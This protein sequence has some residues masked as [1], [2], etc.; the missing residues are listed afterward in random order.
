[1]GVENWTL[2][3][4]CW[5]HL[6]DDMLQV[7]A[8]SNSQLS[9]HQWVGPCALPNNPPPTRSCRH[10]YCWERQTSSTRGWMTYRLH[11]S[12]PLHIRS[13]K[14]VVQIV[15]QNFQVIQFNLSP[16]K[17]TFLLSVPPLLISSVSFTPYLLRVFLW[18][19]WEFLPQILLLGNPVKDI[20]LHTQAVHRN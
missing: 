3:L 17:N 9:F 18:I 16:A 6:G 5:I 13:R 4:P 1:M 11:I 10:S 7:L 12:F 19:I 8:S 14:S 20:G 2:M 15:L